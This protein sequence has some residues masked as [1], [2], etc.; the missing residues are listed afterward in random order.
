[1]KGGRLRGGRLHEASAGRTTPRTVF[2]RRAVTALARLTGRA[3]Q[4]LPGGHNGN[5]THPRAYAQ[6][7]REILGA[8]H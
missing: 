3:P 1:M 5:T 6:R 8:G 4:E 7:V 2:D